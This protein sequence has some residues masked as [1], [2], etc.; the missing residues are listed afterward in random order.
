MTEKYVW[1]FSDSWSDYDLPQLFSSK[2]KALKK[3]KEEF[4]YTMAY[5]SCYLTDEEKQIIRKRF[6]ADKEFFCIDII[7]HDLYGFEKLINT[8]SCSISK[9]LIY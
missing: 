8:R 4:N 7:K 1:V 9:E 2:R 5:F 6:E 3:L